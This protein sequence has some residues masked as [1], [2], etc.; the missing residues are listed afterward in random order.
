MLELVEEAARVCYK[1]EAKMGDT[2][3]S[4]FIRRTIDRGHESV[5]EHSMITVRFT[6]DRGVTHEAVR[7]RIA[8]FSQESTRYCNYSKDSFGNA[9]NVI[10]IRGGMSL[11]PKTSFIDPKD[12]KAIYEEWLI[13]MKNAE[14]SYLRMLDLGASP[15]IARSVLPQ[16]TKA[17]LFVTMNFRQW[18]HFISL[19]EPVTAHPQMREVTIPLLKEFKGAFPVI[20]DDL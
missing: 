12:F 7:H 1:S 8:S 6:V 14:E 3:D 13:A 19:R 10:D 15:Q 4:N 17:D 11:C 18:R 2:F 9:I 16:S 5:I 20:F